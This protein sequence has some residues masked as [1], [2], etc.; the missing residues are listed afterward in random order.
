ML[1]KRTESGDTCKMKLQKF[2][3]H[4]KFSMW[5]LEGLFVQT[6][7]NKD[8]M[9]SKKFPKAD[10]QT[11]F[12]EI[13]SCCSPVPFLQGACS[14][15]HSYFY[16]CLLTSSMICQLLMHPQL[17]S[18]TRNGGTPIVQGR[19]MP[20]LLQPLLKLQLCQLKLQ[21]YWKPYTGLLIALSSKC[22]TDYISQ[23]S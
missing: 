10:I 6:L 11:Q 17:H 4:R 5:L 3:K 20:G 15:I 23:T 7:F 9:N 2:I 22:S 14:Q 19:T 13:H 18:G 8:F 12:T 21:K 1:I 16:S